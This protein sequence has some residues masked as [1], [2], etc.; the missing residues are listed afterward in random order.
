MGRTDGHAWGRVDAA[1][2]D[3]LERAVRAHHRRRLR[4]VGQERVYDGRDG[5]A[6]AGAPPRDG[7]EVV[8]LLDG[9]EAMPRIVEELRRARRHVHL[10]GWYFSP[11]FELVRGPGRLTLVELVAETAAR[12]PVRILAW[13]GSPLALR[14]PNR[15]D[16]R[17]VADA[18][19]EAG[20]EVARDRF[21]RPMHCHHEKLVIVDDEVAFVGGID[22][23]TFQGDRHDD[24]GHPARDALGW[25]DAAA[26][27]R[28]P[29]VADVAAHFA[30]RWHAV[31]GG[32]LPAAAP[33]EP[34]GRSR[35]QVVRTIPNDIYRALPEGDFGILEAY[36]GAL[37]GAR[38]LVY[39][40]NQFLWSPEIVAVLADKLRRPPDDRFRLVVVLPSRP[41]DGADDTRGQLGVLEEADAGGGRLLACTIFAS[42]GERPQDVYVHAKVAVVDDRWLTI[43]SAN[44]NEHSL[45][46][47]TE[48]NLVV[49]DP[50]LA[51][52]VR[53]RLWAEHLECE[54]DDVAGPAHELVDARWRPLAEAGRAQHAAGRPLEQRLV[55]LNPVSQRLER[56]RGPLQGLVVDG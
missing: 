37:A 41:N 34:A 17:R 24:P 56:L 48:V 10:A 29:A 1:L 50:A 5:W 32:T 43:G 15:R 52:D 6:S 9:A 14:R 36:L 20:A 55:L 46:N 16:V 51:R 4:R 49:Q 38:R 33:P 11:E 21:E 27:L 22:L 8:P 13:A 35:V 2:G 53:L 44:L 42:G 3:A 19:R 25:H 39:L 23:T 40:E 47:D 45:F 54:V 18:L 30:L 31:T 26:R 28:G 7:N 12:V